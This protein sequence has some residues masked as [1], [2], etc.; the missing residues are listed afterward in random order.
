LH[1]II[2][3]V[4]WGKGARD[5]NSVCVKKTPDKI[6]PL[7]RGQLDQRLLFGIF[8]FAG[9]SRGELKKIN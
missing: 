4:I 5:F 7:I 2:L 6:K 9:I 3:E 8:N 1:Y